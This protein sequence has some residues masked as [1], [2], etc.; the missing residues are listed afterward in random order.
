[1]LPTGLYRY[2]DVTKRPCLPLS[3]PVAI[4]RFTEGSPQHITQ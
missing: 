4:I 2:D 1:M 3:S